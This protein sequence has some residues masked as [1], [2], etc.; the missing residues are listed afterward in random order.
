MIAP[1]MPARLTDA[2]VL[3]RFEVVPAAQTCFGQPFELVYSMRAPIDPDDAFVVVL[4]WPDGTCGPV[5]APIQAELEGAP[6]EQWLTAA[7]V[8]ACYL[9]WRACA[10]IQI[11]NTRPA[12]ARA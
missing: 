4:R 6:V 5:H 1:V 11:L 10:E 3:S 9:Q 8:R 12:L 2:Q 7:A